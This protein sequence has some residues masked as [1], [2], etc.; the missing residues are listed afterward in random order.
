VR[1]NINLDFGHGG[2]LWINLLAIEFIGSVFILI[3]YF[4]SGKSN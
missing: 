2:I 3:Y 1:K 4:W